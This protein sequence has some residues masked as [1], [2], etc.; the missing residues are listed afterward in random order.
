MRALAEGNIGS[1]SEVMI[2]MIARERL[3][4]NSPMDAGSGD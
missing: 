2:A 1:N 3:D 4:T